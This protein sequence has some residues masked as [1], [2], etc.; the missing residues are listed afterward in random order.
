MFVQLIEA[1]KNSSVNPSDIDF[2]LVDQSQ[3]SCNITFVLHVDDGTEQW[4]ERRVGRIFFKKVVLRLLRNRTQHALFVFGNP[5]RRPSWRSWLVPIVPWE[6]NAPHI[7]LDRSS[8][9]GMPCVYS[10]GWVPDHFISKITSP[11]PNA[12]FLRLQKC[13]HWARTTIAVWVSWDWVTWAHVLSENS[14]RVL[15]LTKKVGF[16]V[17]L[18]DFM[19]SPAYETTRN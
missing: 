9:P 5:D 17:V 10:T 11:E 6:N 13:C 15:K 16:L 18:K 2:I 3:P 4:G 7:Q 19:M 12:M 1:A 8:R 14:H